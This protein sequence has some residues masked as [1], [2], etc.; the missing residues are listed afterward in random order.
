[1]CI[2]DSRNADRVFRS[3][4]LAAR[5]LSPARLQQFILPSCLPVT[6]QAAR[7]RRRQH[8]RWFVPVS[9][10]HLDVYKRQVVL[11]SEQGLLLYRT[12]SF[13]VW[14][15]AGAVYLLVLSLIHI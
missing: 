8:P 3:M 14:A 12:I 2:R 10:T 15:L 5:D 9:Y 13:G 4:L 7:V 1:M 11:S 6:L